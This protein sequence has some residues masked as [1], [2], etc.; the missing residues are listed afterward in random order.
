MNTLRVSLPSIAS[1]TLLDTKRLGSALAKHVYPGLLV[2]L[3]G[4]L[5]AGKTR[6]VI[7]IGRALGVGGVKSPTFAIESIYR[8]PDRAFSLVHA[9]LYRLD[10]TKSAVMQLD[11]YL[12]DGEL[13]LVEWAD[14]WSEPPLENRWDV[15]ISESPEEDRIFNFSAYGERA[16]ETLSLAYEEM[17]D[18]LPGAT[19]CH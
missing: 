4:D 2:L 15:R 7:E 17:T 19:P 13:V 16:S 14:K 8:L 10:E 12:E 18:A 6:L 9:D 3:Y 5:G 11:E 1:R